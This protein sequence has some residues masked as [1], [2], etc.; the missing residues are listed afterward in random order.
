MLAFNYSNL[1]T[2]S[3]TWNKLIFPHISSTARMRI[4]NKKCVCAHIYFALKC[5]IYAPQKHLPFDNIAKF[6]NVTKLMTYCYDLSV[7]LSTSLQ[8]YIM[9]FLCFN[10]MFNEH[11]ITSTSYGY[12]ICNIILHK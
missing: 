11:I 6:D 8:L 2:R 7:F 3:F 12:N 9:T 5:S 1:M 10:F 4:K